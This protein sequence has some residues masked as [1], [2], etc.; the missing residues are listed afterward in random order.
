MS[1]KQYTVLALFKAKPGKE[2]AL[3]QALRNMVQPTLAEDGC[4]NY[5]LH[6][7]ANNK[8]EFMFY[9]NWTSQEAHAKHNAAPHIESWR[10]KKDEL[11]ETDCVV[12][13][14]KMVD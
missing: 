3:E 11:L 4:I 7:S 8:A 1:K 12:T 13:A 5:D 10:K 14:W 2:E 6:C 9:E